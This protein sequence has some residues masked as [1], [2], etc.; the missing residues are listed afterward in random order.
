MKAKEMTPPKRKPKEDH[1]KESHD[2]YEKVL[3]RLGNRHRLILCRDGIQR[4]IQRTAGSSWRGISFHTD[5]VSLKRRL[6]E[7]G[8]DASCTDG[9]EKL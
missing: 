4:I 9:M 2:N 3:A 8:L 7:L 6:T 1:E 5:V